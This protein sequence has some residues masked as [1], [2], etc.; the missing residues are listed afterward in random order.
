MAGEKAMT[1]IAWMRPKLAELAR[2]GDTLTQLWLPDEDTLQA[3]HCLAYASA[4]PNGE[5]FVIDVNKDVIRVTVGVRGKPYK[6]EGGS[7][8]RAICLAIAAA[9]DW[10]AP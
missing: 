9:L 7:L 6:V 2:A 4:G 5:S 3:M 10:E 8:P 1:D